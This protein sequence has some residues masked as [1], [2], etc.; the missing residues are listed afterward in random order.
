MIECLPPNQATHLYIDVDALRRAGIVD[1]LAGPKT[2][3]EPDY[4]AFVDQTGFDYRTD[5]DAVAAA[6]N[7]GDVY[8]AVRGRFAWKQ[9]ANYAAAQGGH[10]RNTICEMPGST[11]EHSISFYPLTSDILALAVSKEP[12]GVT[13]IGPAQWRKPPQLPPDPIWISAP[14]YVFSDTGSLP[15]GTRSF[16]RPL[17][18]AQSVTFA[19][20]P[21]GQRLEVRL[22]A[23]CNSPGQAAD[24]VKQYTQA[25]LLLNNMLQRDHM[26]PNPNDLSGVLSAGVFDQKD[27]RVIGRWPIERG[28]IEALLSGKVD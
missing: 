4:R 17:A 12:R 23:T 27:Q 2:S 21:Q 14:A 24:L 10:C 22:E 18:Q 20:G 3:E 6:F 28:F 26:K 9:L 5:L 13:M 19:A 7:G 16:F 1:L 11:P 25:T 15:A 8:F